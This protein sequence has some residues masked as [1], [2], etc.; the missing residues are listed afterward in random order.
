VS[1]RK[2]HPDQSHTEKQLSAQPAPGTWR[3]G[4][5]SSRGAVQTETSGTLLPASSTRAGN[6]A[7]VSAPVLEGHYE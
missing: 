3:S 5:A 2:Y 7:E 4:R 6:T 1:R